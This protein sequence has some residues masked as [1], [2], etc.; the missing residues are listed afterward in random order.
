MPSI[1]T[2]LRSLGNDGALR[3][4]RG[5]LDER[6]REDWLVAGLAHRLTQREFHA[7]SPAALTDAA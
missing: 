4:V 2:I 6:Q 5:V 1:T 3:N 7:E